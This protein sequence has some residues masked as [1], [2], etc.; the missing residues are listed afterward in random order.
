MGKKKESQ[1]DFSASC[2]DEA[3]TKLKKIQQLMFLGWSAESDELVH[4]FVL[5]A[6]CTDSSL[7]VQYIVVSGKMIVLRCSTWPRA[8]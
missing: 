8:S 7:G 4:P 6:K 5:G 2:V 3:N 1:S